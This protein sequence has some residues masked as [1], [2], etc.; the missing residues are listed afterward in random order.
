MLQILDQAASVEKETEWGWG[1]VEMEKK[2]WK[3]RDAGILYE[4]RIDNGSEKGWFLHYH[5]SVT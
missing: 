4:M 2:K 1:S 5:L 3:Q